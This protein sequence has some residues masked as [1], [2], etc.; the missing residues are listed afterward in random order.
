MDVKEFGKVLPGIVLALNGRRKYT[1]IFKPT[2]SINIG[3]SADFIGLE[4]DYD[5]DDDELDSQAQINQRLA[6]RSIRVLL[7]LWLE[8]LFDG[9]LRDRVK[10]DSWPRLD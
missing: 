10:L 1:H 9:T 7:P 8:R 3:R 4:S 6:A 2:D 5:V